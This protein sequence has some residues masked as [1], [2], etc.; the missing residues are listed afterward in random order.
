MTLHVDSS[1]IRNQNVLA[2]VLDPVD[3][4]TQADGTTQSGDSSST[5]SAAISSFGQRLAAI[6]NQHSDELS[7]INDAESL[8][9]SI[10]SRLSSSGSATAAALHGSIDRSRAAALLVD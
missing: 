5:D 6:G 3:A 9:R 2:T 4:Q 8:V 10:S 7:A 1:T